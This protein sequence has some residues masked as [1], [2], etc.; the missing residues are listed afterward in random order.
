MPVTR[1]AAVV[2]A[3]GASVR[4][5]EPKQ[6]ISIEGEALLRRSARMALEAGCSPVLVVLGS[7]AERMKP[8]LAEL[9]VSTAVNAEWPE[10]MG[11]SLRCGVGEIVKSS[12]AIEALLVLVCD[13]PRLSVEHLRDLVEKHRSGG[14]PITTSFYGGRAGVPAVFAREVFAELMEV[15]GDRGAREVIRRYG[16]RVEKVAWPEG[17][18]DLDRPEDLNRLRS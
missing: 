15:E 13:Q 9:P 16:D 18:L 6:L 3:A 11:S 1:C 12:E 8:A 5:G 4:L 2:L 10:G 14:G 17:E 7:E